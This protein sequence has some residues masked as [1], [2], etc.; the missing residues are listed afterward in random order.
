MAPYAT[1]S[2]APAQAIV[3]GEALALHSP[4]ASRS[5]RLAGSPCWWIFRR[6]S[7]TLYGTRRNSNP[8]SLS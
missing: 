1:G 3:K 5:P 8:S 7:A 6:V 4:V 2:V